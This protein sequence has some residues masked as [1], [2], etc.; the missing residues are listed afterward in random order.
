[1]GTVTSTHAQPHGT[2]PGTSRTPIPE[3]GIPPALMRPPCDLEILIPAKNEARRLPHAL[4]RM[5]RY[6]EQQPYTSA[7]AVIDNGSVDRTVN[8]VKRLGSGRVPIHLVGCAERGKGAAVRRGVLTSSAR[9]RRLHGRRPGHPDRDTRLHRCRCCA[10]VTT[11]SS[12]PGTSAAPRSP[13]R[14]PASGSS[15]VRCSG[16]WPAGSCPASRIA[17]AA[18]SSSPRRP[19]PRGHPRPAGDRVRL[20]RRTAPRGHRPGR[21]REIPVVWSDQDGSTLNGLRDGVK[22]AADVFRL[23]RRSAVLMRGLEQIA[24]HRMLFLN[25]RDLANP[26]AGGAEAYTEQIARRFAAAGA[27]VT[28]FTAQYPDAAAVR[29]G[30]RVPGGPGRRPVRRLR[31]PRRGTC[32]K[33]GRHYDAVVDFQNGIPFFAP[34]FARSGTVVVCVV[35]HVHQGQFD[36]YF[37]WPIT[38]W[39]GCSKAGSA[40]GSTGTRRSSRYLRRR[41]P[42]CAT[43]SASARRSTSCPTAP[44]PLPPST[45]PRSPTPAIAVVTRLVPHKRLH[46]LVEAVPDLL[47]RWP[48]L[49]VDIAGDRAR[50][51][52]AARP[53]S[54]SSA[55]NRT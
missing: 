27:E 11:R 28:L 23:A 52:R 8:L 29:L 32:S 44:D 21:E 25:W 47:R 41:A 49:R 46:L 38:R 7:L 37:R 45:V 53:R 35:H 51:R 43:S 17:S 1:M 19:G 16:S 40:A 14:S 36:L 9:Y 54:G 4:F 55:W 31:W 18:A 26:A 24:G 3:P 10:A 50:P 48:E 34:L 15:A 22:A 39:R 30:A 33:H 5:I 13:S 42:R 2:A 20:R 12:A 6:L